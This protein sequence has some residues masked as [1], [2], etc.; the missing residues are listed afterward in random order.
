MKTFNLMIAATAAAALLAGCGTM[1]KATNNTTT[2]PVT[3]PAKETPARADTRPIDKA[4]YGEWIAMNVNGAVVT[5]DERPY[6]VFDTVA[7]N[8]YIVKFYAYNGCNVINGNMAVTAGGSMKKAS[9][10][11][12]TMKFCPEAQYEIGTSMLLENIDSYKIEKV[13][14]DY[15]LYMYNADKKQS[16]VLRRSDMAWLN[17]AWSVRRIGDT[18][19][20]ADKGLELVIDLPEK[21]LHGNTGCNVLNGDITCNPDVQ[22]AIQFSNIGTTRMMCPDLELEQTFVDALSKVARVD[23]GSNDNE[24]DLRDAEGTLLIELVRLDLKQQ[25]GPD[26]E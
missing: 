2:T 22:N 20:D 10:Y 16:M 9:D 17:G 23:R 6:V 25:A 26:A 21:H 12:S 15:L 5:G 19:I 1:K 11:L 18:G 4:L 3:A 7:V 24:A 8:P 13:A 14:D